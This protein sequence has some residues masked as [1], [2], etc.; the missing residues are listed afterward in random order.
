MYDSNADKQY[1]QQFKQEWKE[2]CKL[3][4]SSGKDLS[5]IIL[6]PGYNKA[7]MNEYGTYRFNEENIK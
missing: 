4:K 5:K 3:L 2:V 6:S 7:R 1:K